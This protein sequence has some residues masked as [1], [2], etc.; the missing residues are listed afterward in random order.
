MQRLRPAN[1]A[2]VVPISKS[3]LPCATQSP[4]SSL[5]A[6]H[7]RAATFAAWTTKVALPLAL[8]FQGLSRRSA[9]RT[10]VRHGHHG[11]HSYGS[12][13]NIPRTLYEFLGVEHRADT[14]TIRKAYLQKQKMVHPD[15]AGDEAQEV[16]M[17]L[18]SAWDVL[19]NT[20]KRAAYD[21]S[22]HVAPHHEEPEDDSPTW[23][24]TP[25]EGRGHKVIYHGR[26]RSRSLYNRV[27]QEERGEKWEEQKFLFVDEL[28]CISCWNCVSCAPKSICMDAD[29]IRARVFAQWGNSEDDLEWAVRSCPVDCISW[30]SR[31][32][33][34]VLEHVTAEHMNSIG[35]VRSSRFS[36]PTHLP[37]LAEKW[38]ERRRRDA[39]FAK[40][41]MELAS[42]HFNVTMEQFHQQLHSAMLKLPP[43][44]REAA[45]S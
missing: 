2:T 29:H 1:M 9:R 17:L 20:E 41:R 31:K 35:C 8:L 39:E 43:E 37:H 45:W 24:W 27:P 19:K 11:H 4:W 30:V 25:K 6:C 14:A 26:P 5:G 42:K 33:L 40:K 22:L 32:E 3:P 12:G 38:V 23:S 28:K 10:A 18:N 16:S 13:G 34:Q 15:V 21:A 36:K 44:L 7:K